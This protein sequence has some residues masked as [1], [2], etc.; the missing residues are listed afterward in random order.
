MRQAA[1]TARRSGSEARAAVELPRGHTVVF[2]LPPL[3]GKR[4]V[5]LLKLE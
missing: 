2:A 1:R 5:L 4:H 3:A